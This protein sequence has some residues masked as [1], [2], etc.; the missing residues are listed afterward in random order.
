MSSDLQVLSS[1]DCV[2][3]IP[4]VLLDYVSSMFLNQYGKS[5]T[6]F[7]FQQKIDETLPLLK[8]FNISCGIEQNC[9]TFFQYDKQYGLNTTADKTFQRK[10]VFYCCPSVHNLTNATI[11]NV[12]NSAQAVAQKSIFRESKDST[13]LGGVIFIVPEPF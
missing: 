6:D 10:D 5:H 3:S 4:A 2:K 9:S 1:F 13:F 11:S 12:C 8:Q 7:H